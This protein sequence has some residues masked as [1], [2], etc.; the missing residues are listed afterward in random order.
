[1][2]AANVNVE[3]KFPDSLDTL[4]NSKPL[5]VEN[6][7]SDKFEQDNKTKSLSKNYARLFYKNKIKCLRKEHEIRMAIL[8]QELCFWE[9]K[10]KLNGLSGDSELK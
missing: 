8:K 7:L 2:I 1:M 5:N 4:K 6:Q 3:S 9:Q 10:T